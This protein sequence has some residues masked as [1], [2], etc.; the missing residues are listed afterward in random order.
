MGPDAAA[1]VV[2]CALAARR[3]GVHATVDLPSGDSKL[4][5]FLKYSGVDHFVTGAPPHPADPDVVI[6]VR[7]HTE[8]SFS[9]P[10][11]IINLIARHVSITVEAEELLRA[12]VNEVIQNV[13]DHARSD[14]GCVTCARFL[15]NRAEVRVAIVD[16]GRGIGTSLRA[17]YASILDTAQA[18]RHVIEGGY[19]AKS[20]PNNM[21]VG[22]SN[23]AGIVVQQFR[24][25]LFIVSEDAFADGK[26]GRIPTARDLGARFPGTAVFF[27][28]PLT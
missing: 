27:T 13:E 14:I 12:C 2:A 6:P 20:R 24:G 26:A 23:L 15:K 10:D 22:I 1:V 9:D 18:L 28:V 17:R 3:Q 16:R 21:G 7:L 8:S 25:E 11:A 5:A 19:T 4:E